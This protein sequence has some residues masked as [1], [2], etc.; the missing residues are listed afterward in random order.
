MFLDVVLENRLRAQNIVFRNSFTIGISDLEPESSFLE[1]IATDLG[2]GLAD[3]STSDFSVSGYRIYQVQ[4]GGNAL[5][6]EK[7]ERIGTL[8]QGELDVVGTRT[9]LPTS[10]MPYGFGAYI[11]QSDS[12][13]TGRSGKIIL[14]T[15]FWEAMLKA[16]FTKWVL[17]PSVGTTEWNSKWASVVTSSTGSWGKYMYGGSEVTDAHMVNLHS[18]TGNASPITKMAVK[19]INKYRLP[20]PS[21]D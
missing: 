10:N 13:I 15:G 20:R 3:L 19:N 17:E 21:V 16:T 2:D 12:R 6:P 18:G 5:K 9:A 14:K 1:G 8:L 11:I 4:Y 7:W